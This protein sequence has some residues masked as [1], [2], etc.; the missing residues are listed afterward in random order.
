MYL[1]FYVFI[2]AVVKNLKCLKKLADD[3]NKFCPYF[4]LSLD[5]VHQFAEALSE[6]GLV[7]LTENDSDDYALYECM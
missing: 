5:R 1:S 4:G 7:T 6:E 2:A 3:K